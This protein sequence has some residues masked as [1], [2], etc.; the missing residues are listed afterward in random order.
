MWK[1]AVFVAATAAVVNSQQQLQ[2]YTENKTRHDRQTVLLGG[3]FPISE[4]D[5][6]Q[7]GKLRVT[8]V[9]AAEAMVFTIQAINENQDLL[10]GVNLTFDIRDTCSIPNKGLENSLSYVQAPMPSSSQRAED[11]MAVSGIVG[12]GFFSHVSMAVASLFRLFQIPQISYGSSAAELSDRRRFDYFFRTLPSDAFLARAIA[13]VV[14]HFNW[15][16]VFALHSDDTFGRS[17]L[18]IMLSKITQQNGSRKCVAVQISIPLAPSVEEFDEIV[19]RMNQ[20]FV[21][22]ATVALL[23]GYKN[24]ATGIMEA[25]RKLVMREPDT[26]LQYLTWVGC[27]AL[28]VDPQYHRFVRGMFRMEYK[29]HRS[30]HFQRHFTSLTPSYAPGNPYWAKYWETKFNCSMVGQGGL[31]NCSNFNQSSYVQ[32]NEISSL[33]DAV[34]AFAHA[35]H[36]LI[37]E[38]CPDGTLCPNITVRRSAGMAVN[39]TMIRDYLLYNLSFPGLSADMVEF[40]SDGNDQSSYVIN[41]LQ[42]QS[43]N[44][45]DYVV[46]G[47]WDPINLVNFTGAIEWNNREQ[48]PESVCSLPCANGS[49]MEF[50]REQECCWAC[51]ECLGENTI[52]TGEACSVCEKGLSPNQDRSLCVVNPIFYLSWSNPW[53]IVIMIATCLGLVAT[54]TCAV[55]FAVFYKHKVVKASSRELSTILLIGLVLCYLLPFFFLAKPSLAICTLRR[56]LVGFSFTVC[57]SALLVKTNRIHRIFNRSPEQFKTQPRFIS[58]LSQVLITLMLISVQVL[59]ALLWLAIEHPSINHT[60]DRTVTELRCGE[61]S[62]VSLVVY[63][64][65]NLLLLILSTYFAFLARKIPENFNE[66]RYINVTLYTIIIIWLAFIPIFLATANLGSLYQI[67]SL[68]TAIILSASTTFCCLFA[69]KLIRLASMVVKGQREREK[70]SLPTSSNFT[71]VTNGGSSKASEISVK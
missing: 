65:Y 9:E 70:D 25:I 61:S 27:E 34:H 42:R 49:F 45:Y 33:I 38:Y 64:G 54:G 5:G 23:Y 11:L 26:P 35:I 29:V 71:A 59:I 40:D 39:G 56:F 15:S 31:P 66:A 2:A 21:R 19:A 60:Y 22:N 55:V 10:P 28:R 6:N 32:K 18:E 63:L 51:Q 14:N 37:E 8:A 68:V 3:L 47:T 4:K 1:F 17:G 13:D 16:Y 30:P 36:G 48:I 7:C 46:V 41:N 53:G 52:S 62:V 67:S 24:Q 43:A 44:S 69:P 58:P 57:F 50:L 20:P 12:A